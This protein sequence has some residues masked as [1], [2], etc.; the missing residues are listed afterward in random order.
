MN[1]LRKRLKR[2]AISK[3]VEIKEAI[4]TF[5]Q[6]FNEMP[7]LNDLGKE[8]A[9][10]IDAHDLFSYYTADVIKEDIVYAR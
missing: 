5:I 8:N 10:R 3:G 4:N 9:D 7:S 1:N 6:P 2:K